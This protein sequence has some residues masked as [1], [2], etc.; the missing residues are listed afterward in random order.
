[1]TLGTKLNDMWKL[2]I[3]T[4]GT[5]N[6]ETR[7]NRNN[8]IWQYWDVPLGTI[9]NVPLGTIGY[10]PLFIIG[11]VIKELDT[12]GMML[13]DTK[14]N[15]SKWFG[16]QVNLQKPLILGD[17]SLSF[18]LSVQY[19]YHGFFMWILQITLPICIFAWYCILQ[20]KFMGLCIH[21]KEIGWFCRWKAWWL[22]A[23]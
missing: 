5:I 9:G 15:N 18:L 13:G 11:W 20:H 10:M 19:F 21:W 3:V 4:L 1:M 14:N 16:I 8:A 12:I 17:S 7:K 23:S 22:W 6:L 2:E